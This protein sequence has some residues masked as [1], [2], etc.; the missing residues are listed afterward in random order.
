MQSIILIHN[1]LKEL[2]R[3]K[4]V[5]Q[6]TYLMHCINEMFLYICLCQT[7]KPCYLIGEKAQGNMSLFFCDTR[8]AALSLTA[9]KTTHKQIIF[10]RQKFPECFDNILCNE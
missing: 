1:H 3:I 7:M 9:K 5:Y 6:F 2:A 8:Y 4:S 10:P